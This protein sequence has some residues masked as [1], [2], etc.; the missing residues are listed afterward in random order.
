VKYVFPQIA[1]PERTHRLVC[2]I[3]RDVPGLARLCDTPALIVAVSFD[4]HR[5]SNPK[6]WRSLHRLAGLTEAKIAAELGLPK[7][8]VLRRLTADALNQSSLQLLKELQDNRVAM[9]IICHAPLI[10]GSFLYA[11]QHYVQTP[12]PMFKKQFVSGLGEM[13]DCYRPSKEDLTLLHNFLLDFDG[14][15]RIHSVEQYRRLRCE[16]WGV[17]ERFDSLKKFDPQLPPPPLSEKAGE[18]E[19]I[20]DWRGLIKETLA[21]KNCSGIDPS[22]LGCIVEGSG[23]FYRVLQSSSMPRAT[24]YIV[25]EE[26]DIWRIGQAR[27]KFNKPLNNKQLKRLSA[28]LADRQ[29]LRDQSLCLPAEGD[30]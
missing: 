3:L 19:A 12:E 25:K 17:L 30:S 27:R 4:V 1:A 26:T 10:S 24:L 11:L 22:L 20:C 18:V 13:P 28:W 21:M 5:L 14:T 23:Y 7:I 6:K 9:R 8:K 15:Q 16:L 29:S 2:S